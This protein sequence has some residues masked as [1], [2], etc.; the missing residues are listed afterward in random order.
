MDLTLVLAITGTVLGALGTLISVLTFLRVHYRQK[1][2]V[3]GEILSVFHVL[4]ESRHVEFAVV[5]AAFTNHSDVANAIVGFLLEVGLP[6]NVKDGVAIH[7]QQESGELTLISTMIRDAGEKSLT[8]PE[9]AEK[10]K[11]LDHP[12]NLNPH[13][14]QQGYVAFPLPS[15][16]DKEVPSVA[17]RLHVELGQGKP[18][19]LS[20]PVVDL[21]NEISFN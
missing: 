17:F 9:P 19:I 14:A 3:D 18:L 16:P 6:Y 4:S 5:E 13:T 21:T 15:I 2:R 11:W 10:L 20:L 12:L 7:R 1:P 8:I